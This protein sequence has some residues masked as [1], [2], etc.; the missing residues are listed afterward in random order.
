MP[1]FDISGD[2]TSHTGSS[3]GAGKNGLMQRRRCPV[4][5]VGWLV[6]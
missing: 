5:V 1:T 4:I 6:G 3:L 2:I